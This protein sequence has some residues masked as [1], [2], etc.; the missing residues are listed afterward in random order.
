MAL[1]TNGRLELTSLTV[2]KK[3]ASG[4]R[5]VRTL[6]R[7]T[8]YRFR[9]ALFHRSG[10][11]VKPPFIWLNVEIRPING[12]NFF[13]DDSYSGHGRHHGTSNWTPFQDMTLL[14][15]GKSRAEYLYFRWFGPNG[16]RL[17][18][19]APPLNVAMH[20]FEIVQ[21]RMSST[22]PVTIS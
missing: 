1:A 9:A 14:V 13:R 21:R 11:V 19:L 12:V 20:T 4:W 3:T 2:Q 10:G 17:S 8:D 6:S 5:R 18:I 15:G 22:V 7:S 16:Q